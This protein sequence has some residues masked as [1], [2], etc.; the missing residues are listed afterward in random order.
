[1]TASA[2]ELAALRAVASRL[3][4]LRKEVVFVG[5]MIRGLLISDPGASGSRPTDDIDVVAEVGSRA[6]YYE[7]AE[8][9]QALGF[10]PDRRE[11]A[12]LCRWL[13]DGLTVDV[14]PDHENVL[15]FTNRW[16]PL[17]RATATWHAVG[18][19]PHDR[20]RVVD[21]PH[22]AAT[23]L[24][25]FRGRGGSDFYHHDMEDLIAMVDGRAELLVELESAP[26][27]TRTFVASEIGS[28]MS[29]EAFREA[30]PGHLA[31]DKASQARLPLVEQR[32]S[33]MAAIR[34]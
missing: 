22:F 6:E 14:M 18:S 13:I 32:L 11:R 25:S 12:P 30:L 31:G 27:A 21:A 23:K 5:G 33:A 26:D 8:R 15:G 7:L 9:L 20:I 34:L 10:V 1:M 28:L 24:E 19:L 29:E 3:G 2:S 17:A 4:P 16:Y